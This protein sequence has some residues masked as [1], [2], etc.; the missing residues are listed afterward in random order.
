M[1][2]NS[3]SAGLFASVCAIAVGATS[4]AFAQTPA[5]YPADYAKLVEAAKAEGTVVVYSTTDAKAFAPLIKD[6]EAYSGLKI[7]FNDLNSTELYNRLIAETAA[8]SGTADLTLSS[9]PDLQV[10]LVADGLAETYAS[11]E[12][13]SLPKWSVLENKA[14]GM[15][16]EPMAIIYNKTL[17]P[18][19]DVPKSH[20]DLTKLLQTKTDAYKGKVTAYDPERSG[21]GFLMVNRDVIADPSAWDLFK[22]MGAAGSK[23]YTSNGAMIEKVGSGE[24]SIAYNIFGSYALL[25]SKKNPNLR[26]V[27]PSDYTLIATRVAFI[28]I[29]AKHP[30]AGKLMLDYLLSKRGQ[31]LIAKAQ[32]FSIR[33]D[34]EGEATAKTVNAKLGD[35]VRPIPVSR[36]LLETLE[37]SRR[38]EFMTKWQAA[39][40]VK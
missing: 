20:A 10:K 35:K 28:P 14:Y 18:E 11:P 31:E 16:Y 8:G 21:V 32:L 25:Q 3:L 33:D 2:F 40:T 4:T 36:E 12:I 30:N 27:W 6:F 23:Y 39:Q 37:Q 34:V 26:T 5:G 19:A 1:N 22:A 38:L 7:E 13:A 9:A 17:V 29:K 15:T 24:H